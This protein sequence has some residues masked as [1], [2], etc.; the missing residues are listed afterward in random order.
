MLDHTA[1]R[2]MPGS[3]MPQRELERHWRDYRVFLRVASLFIAHVAVVLLLL[4]YFLT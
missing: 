3:T 2:V 4:A 1:D